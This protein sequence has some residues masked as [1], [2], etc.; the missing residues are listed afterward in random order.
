[1]A[2][3][4]YTNGAT[5]DGFSFNGFQPPYKIGRAFT[6]PTISGRNAPGKTGTAAQPCLI[7]EVT[8][9]V[10]GKDTSSA[11]T[12]FAVWNSNGTG[13]AYSSSFNLP[14]TSSS[15]ASAVSRSL[16]KTA[17]GG[18]G[19]IVGFTKRNSETFTW[20]EDNNFGGSII[21]DNNSSGGDFRNDGTYDSGSLIFSVD[22]N[23]LPTAPSGLSATPSGT[24]I[25][26]SWS[27]PSSDGGTSI[28]GYRV[29]RSTDNANWTTLKSNSGST[30]RSYT[31]SGLTAGTTYYYRVAAHNAVSEAHGSTYSGPYSASAN[32]QISAP[33]VNSGATST[34]DISVDNPAPTFFEFSD[35]ENGIG[36]NQIQITYGSEKLYNRVVATR[37]GGE[38]QTA[39]AVPSQ[40]V[41]GIRTYEISGLLNNSDFGAISAA[42]EMLYFFYEPDLR[43]EAI[44]VELADK[45]PEDKVAILTL[46]L[47]D[48]ISVSFTPNGIGD[49]IIT[50]GRIIGIDHQIGLDSHRVTFRLQSAN[51]VVFTLDDEINGILDED[52]LG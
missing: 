14:S 41:Y 11:N 15:D 35:S 46:D 10:N 31:D 19:Y 23:V 32:A 42:A 30:T 28:T 45:S 21:R 25:S 36:F 24:T 18:T 37:V 52:L 3:A 47:D 34:I 43:I 13:G 38:P 44:G 16:S 4:T 5:R 29:Q 7:T 20:D 51:V 40:E 49:P 6:M 8:I 50:E 39:D 22:Y 48:A 27:A 12:Q 33:V 26:L 1:M 2:F 17:F 9:H